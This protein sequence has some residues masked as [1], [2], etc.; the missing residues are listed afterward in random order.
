MVVPMPD[1]RDRPLLDRLMDTDTIVGRSLERVRKEVRDSVLEE[2]GTHVR[3]T[4]DD[5]L[6]RLRGG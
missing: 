2:V 6:R 3:E 5:R 4:V 1:R